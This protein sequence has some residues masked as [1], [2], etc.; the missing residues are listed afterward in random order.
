MSHQSILLLHSQ[1]FAA[2]VA[3]AGDCN[4]ER[5]DREA[6]C[7]GCVHGDMQ[8][9]SAP[10]IDDELCGQRLEVC[11]DYDLEEGGSELCWSQGTVM[12]VSDGKN[13]M[14]PGKRAHTYYPKGYAV[15]I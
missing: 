15:M 9:P 8:P 3:F 10:D 7:F 14:K 13:I 11:C 1:H 4:K 12:L 2:S 6:D 5:G